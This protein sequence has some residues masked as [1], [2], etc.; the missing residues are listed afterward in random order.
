MIRAHTGAV[1]PAAL[2]ACPHTQTLQTRTSPYEDHWACPVLE[3][4]I[5][6]KNQTIDLFDKFCRVLKTLAYFCLLKPGT[7][8]YGLPPNVSMLYGRRKHRVTSLA[9]ENSGA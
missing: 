2:A 5:A 6:A 9:S 4:C 3:L 1:L 7:R 8:S